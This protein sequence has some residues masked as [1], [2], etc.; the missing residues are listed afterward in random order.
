MKILNKLLEKSFGRKI[1]PDIRCIG[2]DCASRSGWATVVTDSKHCN[3]EYGFVDID[4]T[5]IY[6]KYDYMIDFFTGFIE[7]FNP[8]H[9]IIEDTFL[10]FNVNVLKKLSRFGMIPYVLSKGKS[11]RI[12]IGP[13]EARKQ[14]D[15]PGNKKKAE[16]HQAFKAKLDL[17]LE[18]VDIVDA[19]ILC[20]GGIFHE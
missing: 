12:F 10:R 18:D 7:K 2:F 5:D 16:V 14:L 8:T 9:I 4:T 6:Y 13:S 20:L 11:R 15:L 3:L 17:G 1:K 19:I